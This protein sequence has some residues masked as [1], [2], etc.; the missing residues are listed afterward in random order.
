MSSP[1][2]ALDSDALSAHTADNTG[3]DLIP[4][5][6]ASAA[7]TALLASSRLRLATRTQE[8]LAMQLELDSATDAA[9]AATNNVRLLTQQRDRLLSMRL[10]A[11]QDDRAI[12]DRDARVARLTEEITAAEL[13]ATT[14]LAVEA[15]F[16]N[17][18]ERVRASLTRLAATIAAA[19]A[20]SA[21][22]W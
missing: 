17:Q 11:T 21:Q 14:H 1:Q 13:A 19:S 15:S 3:S 5:E 20:S 16:A 8:M 9:L 7:A 4:D 18:L 12:A 2:V 10:V 6:A 22:P